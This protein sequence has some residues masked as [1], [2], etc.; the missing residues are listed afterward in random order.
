MKKRFYYKKIYFL[1]IF[2]IYYIFSIFFHLTRTRGSAAPITI[3][4]LVIQKI[5]GFNRY[6]YWPVHHSSVV[7]NPNN[8]LI[9]KGTAPGLS[10]GCYI[11]GIGT[12]IIGDYTL[13]GPN[14]GLIS[15]NH[16]ICDYRNHVIGS[17]V[18]GNYCWIGMNSI[19]L[20]NVNLGDHTIVAAGSVVTKPFPEGYSILGGNPAIVIKKINPEICK[21]YKNKYEYYGYIPSFIFNSYK[22]LCLNPELMD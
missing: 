1:L 10:P 19:I 5:L 16:D 20:P 21:K 13:I 9:G 3:K 2:S 17:I 22:E 11:Q 15:A 6:A 12:I 8:I 18:I 4:T 7:S 14:V